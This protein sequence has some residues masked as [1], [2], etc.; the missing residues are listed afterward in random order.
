[1]PWVSAAARA[2]Y[3]DEVSG[4]LDFLHAKGN[5]TVAHCTVLAHLQ[6]VYMPLLLLGAEGSADHEE[7]V[8]RLR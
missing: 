2:R 7:V 8:Y 3:T 1:M 4:A 6:G 5:P